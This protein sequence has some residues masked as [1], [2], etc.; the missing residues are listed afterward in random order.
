MDVSERYFEPSRDDRRAHGVSSSSMPSLDRVYRVVGECFP[1][2]VEEAV[3]GLSTAATLLLADQQNPVAVNLEGVPSSQKTSLVDF[4]GAADGKVYRSDKF[5]PKSFVSHSASISREKLAEVDLLPRIKHKV[6][7]VP[8][9]A[10]LFGLRNE[11]LL[12]SFSILTRVLDGQGFESDSGV[13]GSRGYSGDYLFAWI[14]C[15]TPI[16]H[17]VWKTM[18]KLGSRFLF[19]EMSADEQ[20]DAELVR[21]AAGGRSYRERVE[22][23]REVVADFLEDL[24]KDAGGVRGVE[25]D[26]A[27]DPAPVMMRIAAFA[28]VLARLRGTISIWR[29]GSGDDETYNFSTPVIEGPQR[30]MSLL[31]ALARGH[32]LV[33]G[34]RQL[35]VDDLPIVARA[36]LESTPN[37]RRAVMRLLL[38]NEG[39][40][41]TAD[42]QKALRCSAPT[43]RAIL[44]TLDKLGIGTLENPGPPEPA[45]LTLV[46]QLG[47]LLDADGVKNVSMPD[48]LKENRRREPAIEKS[49]T[50]SV[51]KV[52]AAGSEPG[53][54]ELSWRQAPTAH[55]TLPA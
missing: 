21:D 33:H 50:P 2:I 54:E 30:A 6:F 49:L 52:V 39:T 3:I 23:C 15:T 55:L 19:I 18:G 35:T 37:D 11:D 1:D 29:E 12:E 4:F 32:A 27:A 13:H 48:A 24:W 25:W 5:T 10:P 45:T 8:E 20:T 47:W 16:P 31:Y 42:I 46:E 34:R 40:V 9:L 41:T 28:K 43:A 14:G 51:A 7:L 17:N 44:E 22:E 38:R 26:R 53:D 36:S